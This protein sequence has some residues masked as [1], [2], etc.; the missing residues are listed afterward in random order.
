MSYQQITIILYNTR[1]ASSTAIIIVLLII[2]SYLIIGVDLQ[3]SLPPPPLPGSVC[4]LT[5]Q[6]YTALVGTEA[7][8]EDERELTVIKFI[9][10][11]TYIDL[12]L[13]AVVNFSFWRY[14][15]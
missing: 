11:I 8:E 1:I 4:S 3:A 9:E 2:F 12:L 15:I 7:R 10:Q 13:Y 14:C 6:V 5:L